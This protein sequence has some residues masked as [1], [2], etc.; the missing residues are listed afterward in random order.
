MSYDSC[1]RDCFQESL[2]AVVPEADPP[3]PV[4]VAQNQVVKKSNL[5]VHVHMAAVALFGLHAIL[6]LLVN[7]HVPDPYM[8]CLASSL[9]MTDWRVRH[10]IQY[11]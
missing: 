10:W 2:P 11:K 5:N 1:T 9:L 8:V 4:A 7:H 3:C 6:L